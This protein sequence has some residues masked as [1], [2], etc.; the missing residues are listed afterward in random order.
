MEMFR[1]EKL[2][3]LGISN[4]VKRCVELEDE[5]VNLKIQLN[6]KE[7]ERKKY[8]DIIYNAIDVYLKSVETQD[9]ST[10]DLEMY[11]ILKDVKN[12]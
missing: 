11:E 5:I 10:C 9:F 3:A 2:E 1:N 4:A 6:S 12:D 7:K 8:E